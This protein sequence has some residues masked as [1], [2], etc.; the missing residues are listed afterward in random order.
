[1]AMGH[2]HPKLLAACAA[3]ISA[4]HVGRSPGLVNEDEV[5]AIKIELILEPLL[6][7]GQ[8]VGTILLAGVRGLFLRV[9]A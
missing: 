6:A 4:R 5:L 7:P 1:M 3:P 2:A 8:D 9:M